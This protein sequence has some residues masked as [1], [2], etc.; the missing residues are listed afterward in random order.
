M[1]ETEFACARTHDECCPVA[2]G[3]DGKLQAAAVQLVGITPSE[4]LEDRLEQDQ[5][6]KPET[7]IINVPQIKLHALCGMF[8][9]GHS[10]SDP[11][12]LRPT[13]YAGLDVMAKRVIT[14]QT[15]KV[16]VVCQR[17]RTRP[18]QR[19]VAPQHIP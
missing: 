2:F 12:A 9:C 7:P 5:K 4:N 17:M 6:V 14:Q 18:Y 19:H 1:V 10:A 11:V 3:S 16:V 15:F 13:C 8:D